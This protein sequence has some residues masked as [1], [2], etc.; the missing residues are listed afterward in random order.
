MVE[1]RSA[2]SIIEQ[3]KRVFADMRDRY[4]ELGNSVLLKTS[5]QDQELT[6]TGLQ[7]AIDIFARQISHMSA[8]LENYQARLRA[9][10]DTTDQAR[11]MVSLFTPTTPRSRFLRSQRDQN[12]PLKRK[13][14]F[15]VQ[16]NYIFQVRNTQNTEFYASAAQES[17]EVMQKLTVQMHEKTM[18]MH[19]ITIFT[20]IFLPGTF[21]AVCTP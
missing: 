7:S 8:D 6:N 1:L 21:V 3:N 19:L 9:I 15:F 10:L 5:L 17:S 18:S 14:F 4:V 13:R 20:L 16:Y 11:D 2:V 12:G